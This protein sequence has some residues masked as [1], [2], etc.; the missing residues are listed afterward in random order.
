MFDSNDTIQPFSK[1]LLL[2]PGKE[3]GRKR[4]LRL[5]I[6]S[7]APQFRMTADQRQDILPSHDESIN[8]RTLNS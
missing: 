1:L 3:L 5:P 4:R 6:C 2:C 8:T 7:T